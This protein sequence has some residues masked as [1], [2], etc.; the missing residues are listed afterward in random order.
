[1]PKAVRII[2]L[3]MAILMGVSAIGMIAMYV[4]AESFE[5]VSASASISG[6]ETEN[7]LCAIATVADLAFSAS[8]YYRI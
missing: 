2:A 5:G 3:I 6:T 7:A 4:S 8:D 1:M